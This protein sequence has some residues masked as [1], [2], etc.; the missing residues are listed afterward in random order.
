MV[1]E[2]CTHST[3]FR[4]FLLHIFHDS[5]AILLSQFYLYDSITFLASSGV[6]GM[7]SEA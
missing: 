6:G 5:L 7:K 1:A 4:T 3:T 2:F